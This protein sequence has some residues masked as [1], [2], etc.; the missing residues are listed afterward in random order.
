[1]CA[2]NQVS[3]FVGQPSAQRWLDVNPG[4]STDYL[5]FFINAH[6]FIFFSYL[7]IFQFKYSRYYFFGSDYIQ[8]YSIH[9]FTET[10]CVVFG[11]I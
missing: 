4:V 5:V 3:A 1:M 7:Q 8:V 11:C 9:R 6:F 10:D 2:E